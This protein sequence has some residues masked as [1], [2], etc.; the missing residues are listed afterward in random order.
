MK[1]ERAGSESSR[2]L[3]FGAARIQLRRLYYG[4]VKLQRGPVVEFLSTRSDQQSAIIFCI[5]GII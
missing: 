1:T 2:L 4:S 3:L 5:F